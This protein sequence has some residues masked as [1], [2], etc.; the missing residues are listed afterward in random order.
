MSAL[1][2][3]FDTIYPAPAGT[4]LIHASTVSA[5]PGRSVALSV[6]VTMSEADVANCTLTW[7]APK[8]GGSGNAVAVAVC[9]NVGVGVAVGVAVPTAVAVGVGVCSRP[10][11]SPSRGGV[12]VAV[13]VRVGVAVAVDVGVCVGVWVGV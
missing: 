4:C 13:G 2:V 5:V 8:H 9:V 6:A 12:G 10:V 7:V 3:P 1:P 11:C